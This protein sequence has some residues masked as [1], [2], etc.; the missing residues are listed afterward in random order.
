MHRLEKYV[1]LNVTGFHKILKKHDR[2]LP[3]PCKAFYILRL[4]D[5]S[6]VRGDYSDVL[7]SMSK[8]YTSLRGDAEV[9]AKETERQDFVRS[10]RKYWV[11]MED[12]SRVKYI[13]LQHLPVF[14]QKTMGEQDSQLVNSVYLDNYSLELYQGR[15][16]KTP[17]AIALRFRWYGTGTPEIVFVER[18][19]HREAWTGE[20]SVKERFIIKE[21]QVPS[22]LAGTFNIDAE[23]SRMKQKGKSSEEINEW[24]ELAVE[25]I[26][27]INSKQLT[28]TLRTQYMRTAFQIPFDA[29]VRVSLDTNLCMIFERTKEVVS[30]ARWFRDPHNKIPSNEI[31]R[32]PHAVLEI[33]LQLEDES[34]TP[35]WVED[36]IVSGM[37]ME[38]HK[39]SKFIHGCSVLLSDEVRAAPYWIDD[40]TLRPSIEQSGATP[41]LKNRVGANEV[42]NHLLPHDDK[43]MVKAKRIAAMTAAIH[44]DILPPDIP[45]GETCSAQWYTDISCCEGEPYQ[46][47]HVVSQREEPKSFFANERT[48]IKWLEMAVLMSGIS[49][50]VLAF[51]SKKSKSTGFALCMLVMAELF[52]GYALYTFLWRNEKIKTRYSGRWDDPWGPPI[53]CMCLI[54]AL[55]VR[56][57]LLATQ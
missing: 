27:A 30:G 5:Q 32:F 43:G 23:V 47:K 1:N 48:F 19:T 24:K 11:H 45:A 20:V 6:W 18:K 21:D 8:A 44:P 31:T 46:G 16:D 2:R 42:Y 33:K 55:L 35:T 53:L 34:K 50:G 39:F 26:Q 52:I 40:V 56:A 25:V 7:V 14:M 12:I 54:A 13:I 37:L 9:E 4:H 17:G 10:T 15:L 41:L 3:N 29:T 38:V 22:L 36:L 49:I 28:P 57:V 51:S